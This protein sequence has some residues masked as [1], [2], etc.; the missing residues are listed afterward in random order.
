MRFIHSIKFRFTIWYV[1]V[2]GIAMA[3]LSVG[4]YFY[5]SRTLYQNLDNSLELRSTQLSNIR[6]ILISVAEGQFEEEIGEVVSFYFYSGGQLMSISPREVNIPISTDLIEQ[7]IA[8]QSIFTTLET[9]EGVELRLYATP[10]SLYRPV[11]VPTRPG[12]PSPIAQSFH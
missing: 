4:T 10:F 8:G 1:V 5:L 11:I 6:E 2:L 7:A 3:S 12:M 9:S